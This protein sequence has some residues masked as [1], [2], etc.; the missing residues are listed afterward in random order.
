[1]SPS[2]GLGV[3]LHIHRDP[4]GNMFSGSDLIDRLLH[5][6]V[7]PIG[8]FHR[9]GSRRQQRVIEKG[10]RLLD[11]RREQLFQNFA[12]DDKYG[13]VTILFGTAVA[14]RKP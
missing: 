1:L 8:S 3:S 10:Q 6:S 9:V 5:L 2:F 11:I 13:T 7:S 14:S 12:Q 4:L